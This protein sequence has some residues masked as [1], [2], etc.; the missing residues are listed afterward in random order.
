M[1]NPLNK[2]RQPYSCGKR[3]WTA[4]EDATIR[5]MVAADCT[6]AEIGATLDRTPAAIARH[7]FLCGLVNNTCKEE[8]SP[9]E[10]SAKAHAS[11][12]AYRARMQDA[13]GAGA[14]K[15]PRIASRDT[16]KYIRRSA[17]VTEAILQSPMGWTR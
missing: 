4:D 14:E 2:K 1:A 13:I 3:K 10:W 7:R 12:A 5:D 16:Q 6:D 17:P 9:K 15:M 8:P 11:D